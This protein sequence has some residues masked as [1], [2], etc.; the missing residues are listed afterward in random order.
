MIRAILFI[1]CC[2]MLTG[3]KNQPEA[4]YEVQTKLMEVPK[5]FPALSIPEDN[6]FTP[7]RWA[8][9][10]KLFF[11]T[12]MSEDRSISCASCHHPNKAFS[13][14]LSVSLGVA[15]RLG[16][17]NAPTLTNVAY[18]PYFTREG[19]VPTLEMQI[20]V[21]IQE[22]NEFNSNIVLI[23]ERLNKDST[24]VKMAQQ[25]YNR[26]PDPFVITRAI[27]CFERSLLSGNSPYDQ[28]KFQ[29]KS[30]ALSRAE[31]RGMDLFFS[32]KTNCSSCHNGFNFTNYSFVNT[33][34]YEIYTDVG[35][36]RL[37]NKNQD[38]ALFKVPT[39]RNVGITAPY[40]HDG[41]FKTLEQVVTHYNEGGK[42]HKH[43]SELIRPL[44]L[45]KKEKS[46]LVVFLHTLTDEQFSKNPLFN[47]EK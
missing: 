9:G 36:F 8:L 22:H 41:S 2:M 31:R 15:K 37:T 33:G 24:Y 39:L 6:A 25:A 20:L 42:S 38:S 26:K 35:R 17:R 27:A 47:N 29:H 10:K 18:H 1:W 45:T 46:D 11:D 19:G 14:T 21:P 28:F 13:D 34:L 32:D 16:T 4:R 23:A 3:C 30:K 43:K 7:E 5:G 12:V 44:K 40:M